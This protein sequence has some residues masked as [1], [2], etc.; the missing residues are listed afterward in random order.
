MRRQRLKIIVYSAG[1]ARWNK[2]VC[3]GWC[4]HH[5]AR[6]QIWCYFR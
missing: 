3:S 6:Q 5:V 2:R 1:L 4:C